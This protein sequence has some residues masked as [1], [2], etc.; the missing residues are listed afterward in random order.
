M[1]S[2]SSEKENNVDAPATAGKWGIQ[3]QQAPTGAKTAGDSSVGEDSGAAPQGSKEDPSWKR[4]A[5]VT[6][7]LKA[8]I[9]QMKVCATFRL[10]F[11]FTYPVN[12]LSQWRR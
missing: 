1:T 6:S 11:P 8:R 4:A 12:I 2:P 10:P 7:Q 9:E 3:Q 5:E